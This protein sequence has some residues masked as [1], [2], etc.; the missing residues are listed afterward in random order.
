VTKLLRDEIDSLRGALQRVPGK[1]EPSLPQLNIYSVFLGLVRELKKASANDPVVQNTL[2]VLSEPMPKQFPPCD[3]S[4]LEDFSRQRLD[5][6]VP[7]L[8]VSAKQAHVSPS[9]LKVTEILVKEASTMDLEVI[10]QVIL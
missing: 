5:L 4:F 10:F 7:C 6:L 8:K 9:A 3:W 2:K 1:A